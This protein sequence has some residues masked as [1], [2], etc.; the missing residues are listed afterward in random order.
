MVNSAC[1]LSV[2]SWL[3][4]YICKIYYPALFD[5]RAVLLTCFQITHSNH[6][7][8]LNKQS[9]HILWS[10]RLLIITVIVKQMYRL[11]ERKK[12]NCAPF[13]SS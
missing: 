7:T 6:F 9:E 4:P 11:S 13:V 3:C 5:Q 12:V 1:L 8:C 2:L 10:H